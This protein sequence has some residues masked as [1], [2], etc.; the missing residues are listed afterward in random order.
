MKEVA[1]VVELLKA[2]GDEMKLSEIVEKTKSNIPWRTNK[3]NDMAYFMKLD[4]RIAKAPTRGYYKYTEP[5]DRNMPKQP[6]EPTVVQEPPKAE[7]RNASPTWDVEGTEKK[8]PLGQTAKGIVNKVEHYGVFVDLFE[9]GISGLIHKSNIK[10]GKNFYSAEE[11][12]RHF[13]V[14]D[15]ITVRI[16]T[17]R[18][19][20]L[21]LSTVGLPI[22]DHGIVQPEIPTGTM[23]DKL[24]PLAEAIVATQA[25]A[26]TQ[27]SAPA[28]APAPAPVVAPV[29]APT[30]APAPVIAPAPTPAPEPITVSQAP[31]YAVSKDELQDL[32][33]MIQK[34]VGVISYHAKDAL[35]ESVKKYGIVKVTMA[36]MSANDFEAD[37]SLAF[38]RFVET[39]ASGG[40]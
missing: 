3:T 27:A 8:L 17:Y 30:P 26:A 37:V 35:K 14:G 23:A 2:A 11:I 36:L 28:A 21:S 18:M 32:Y 24:R 9:Y 38:V 6:E 5:G 10:R 1:M 16:I 7:I 19:G 39:K 31:S 33:E 4:K 25:N 40:L 29:V 22:P 12:E 13:L 15:E 20:K 34:K